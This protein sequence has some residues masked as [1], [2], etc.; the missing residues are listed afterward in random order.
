MDV[1]PVLILRQQPS[2]GRMCGFANLPD[3]R[4]LYELTKLSDPPL[5]LQLKVPSQYPEKYVID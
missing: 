4:M 1:L 3:R 5:I 2:R